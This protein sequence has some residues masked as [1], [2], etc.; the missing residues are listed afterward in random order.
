MVETF[1]GIQIVA[2]AFCLFMIY[3]SFVHYK[4]KNLSSGEFI[5]WVFSWT[6]VLF[7]AFFPRVLDPLVSNLF[8][9]RALDLVMIAAFVILSYLGFQN[10]IGVKSLQRQIQAIVSQQALK[11]AKKKK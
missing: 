6:T 5:F 10:H 4:R 1:L 9:A 11:N 2:F 3:L 8:V 7:F